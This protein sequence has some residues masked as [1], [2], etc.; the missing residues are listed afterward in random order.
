MV[1]LSLV[2]AVIVLAVVFAAQNA[3]VVNL[4]L[5]GWN[6]DASLAVIIVLCFAAGALVAGLALAPGI[7]RGRSEQRKMSQRLAE[8]EVGTDSPSGSGAQN[9]TSSNAAPFAPA[10]A[11]RVGTPANKPLDADS[12]GTAPPNNDTSG[13]RGSW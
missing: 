9:R 7:Y 4:S 13:A 2:L 1:R 12:M 8:L 5:L 11:P 6:M 10:D 3:D